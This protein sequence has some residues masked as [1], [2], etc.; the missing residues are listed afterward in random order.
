M[1]LMVSTRPAVAI[2]VATPSVQID[3]NEPLTV[4]GFGD[5]QFGGEPSDELLE[6]KVPYVSNKTCSRVYDEIAPG[7]M[8]AGTESGWTDACPGDSGGP[9][10]KGNGPEDAILIGIIS[11]GDGCGMPLKYGVYTRVASE[12][13]WIIKVMSTHR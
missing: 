3:I 10:T 8:C 5:T 12:T 13:E 9:L 11:W 7:M 4:A 1:V 6:G 2:P